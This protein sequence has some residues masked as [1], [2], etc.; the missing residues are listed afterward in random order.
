MADDLPSN[1][2]E[3]KT[4]A[5][6]SSLINSS[7]DIHIVLNN[8]MQCIQTAMN[9][10]ASAIFEVDRE[11]EE[12]FFRIA[13]GDAADRAKEVRVKIG[14]G[15]A[16]WVAKTREPLNI[17]D[18]RN[19]S[20]FLALVDAQTGFRTRSILCVPIIYKEELSGVLEVLNKKDERG[21]DEND[22]E[23]LII[24]ANQI[25]IALENAR[26]FSRL[27]ERFA[28]TKEE[29]KAT[30][31]KLLQTERL[32]A[33][34][35][36][37]QGVAHEVRNPVMII[38][39][40]VRRL[41][42]QFN[43]NAQIQ[44]TVEIVLKQTERLER[45]VADIEKL[46][47]LRSPTLQPC[48]IAEIVEK[49]LELIADQIESRAIQVVK[50]LPNVIPT[51]TVDK[52]LLELALRNIMLNAAEAMPTGGTLEVAI[53]PKPKGVSLFVR[54][55]GV[56]IKPEDLPN[57]FDPFFTSKTQ[58]SGI[59]LTAAHHIISDHCGDIKVSSVPGQGTEVQIWLP[60]C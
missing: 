9:S 44:E 24:L 12:L 5:E 7:L 13:L 30:Q 8:A 19:D 6:L 43:D 22:M 42:K 27:R 11:R 36:L 35:K 47:G 26:L 21:F 48:M 33:L 38:G 14:E 45:M 16:G 32:A 56:G 59:G 2:C 20:R 40:F 51:I 55:T 4:L 53:N 41:Q 28:L 39:G 50:L 29:L 15:V 37:S 60:Y 18:T 52:E 34:G 1:E 58:G 25:A 23:M 31:E 54:D 3:L 46:A 57:I 10:E 17:P 49:A